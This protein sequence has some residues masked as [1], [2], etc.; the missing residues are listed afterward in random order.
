MTK[1]ETLFEFLRD[2]ILPPMV[3]EPPFNDANVSG[4]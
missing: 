3:G 4:R 1:A 2:E